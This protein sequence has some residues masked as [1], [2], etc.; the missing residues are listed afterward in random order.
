MRGRGCIIVFRLGKKALLL[1]LETEEWLLLH[2]GPH[3]F[4]PVP[5]LRESSHLHHADLDLLHVEAALLLSLVDQNKPHSGVTR[6][7]A[8]R[9]KNLRVRYTNIYSANKHIF[10]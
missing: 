10:I 4:F 6:N 8:L 2:G 1:Y 9:Y 3:Q 7:A 5:C